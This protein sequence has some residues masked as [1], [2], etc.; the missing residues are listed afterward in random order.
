MEWWRV[1]WSGG[2]CCGVAGSK[3]LSSRTAALGVVGKSIDLCWSG[4]G[5]QLKADV[6]L[7][8]LQYRGVD[9]MPWAS[10]PWKG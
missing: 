9:Y 10:S 1:L 4:L 3:L 6:D 5:L 7:A 8:M 2:G